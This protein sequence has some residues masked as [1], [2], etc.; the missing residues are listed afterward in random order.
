MTQLTY[1]KAR[2]R[3]HLPPPAPLLVSLLSNAQTPCFY[4]TTVG[5]CTP[6]S[7]C[8][9]AH[10]ASKC[11]LLHP[12]L[13]AACY[14]LQVLPVAS[15]MCCLLLFELTFSTLCRPHVSFSPSRVLVSWACSRF[16]PWWR[17]GGTG[18]SLPLHVFAVGA[19]RKVISKR[20]AAA[21]CRW[22]LPPRVAGTACNS[23][24]CS[25]CFFVVMSKCTTYAFDYVCGRFTIYCS[26]PARVSFSIDCYHC[27]GLRRR[28]PSA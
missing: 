6:A 13:V 27:T 3:K 14:T 11:S 2:L 7:G 26:F 9:P 28:K 22:A 16:W 5:N 1:G 18:D 15:R 23:Y 17:A 19:V 25:H 8:C 21:F 10:F 24:M 4:C 20:T 12:T